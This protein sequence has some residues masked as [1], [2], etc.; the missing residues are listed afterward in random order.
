MRK[1]L[2]FFAFILFSLILNAQ[3]WTQ[4]NTNMVGA[5]IGVDQISA[6]DSNIVWINGFN[7]AGTTDR[8]KVCARSQDGGTTWVPGTYN[9]FGATVFP[10]VLTGVTYNKAFAIAMDTAVGGFA[11][12]WKTTD[13]GANWSLVTG[14]MN[15]GS[16][17]FANAVLFWDANKG[18]CMGDPVSNK[19][20]IYYTTDGGTTWTPALAANITTPISGEYGYNGFECSSKMEGG[21]AAFITN[22]GRVYKTSNYG[23][24]WAATATAPFTAVG[25]GKIYVTGPNK[26]IAAGMLT[27]ATAYTWKQT[28]DGGATWTAYAPAGTFYTYAM[29]YVPYSTNMLVSTSPFSTA[30]GVSYSNDGGANWTDFTNALLQP[31]VGTNIQCL[32]VGFADINNGWVGNYDATL[33]MN[34]I[35][36]YKNNINTTN[37]INNASTVNLIEV[38]P[39]PS[40]GMVYFTLSGNNKANLSILDITGKTIYTHLIQ[41]NGVTKTSFDFSNYARGIYFVKYTSGN[42]VT[43]KKLVIN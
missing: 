22:M 9:G 30:K 16:T 1:Q 37:I 33:S 13:G 17:T 14:I 4:Q 6:V 42:D 12:F 5:T 29:A 27:G 26:M 2:F 11:S 36:K 24:N 3:T 32:G 15:N 21:Y 28:I 41:L 43:I 40:N 20:D 8:A 18:F 7:G 35:L 23:V 25:T 31:T 19:F 10:Q 34:S 39:N 38:Y